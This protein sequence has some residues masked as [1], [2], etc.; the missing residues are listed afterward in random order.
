MG[1]DPIAHTLPRHKQQNILR[2]PHKNHF[3]HIQSDR[4]PSSREVSY[5]HQFRHTRN[6]YGQSDLTHEGKLKCL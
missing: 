6:G 5:K 1:I 2:T 3:A 4:H